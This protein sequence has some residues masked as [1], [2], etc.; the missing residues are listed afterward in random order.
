MIFLNFDTVIILQYP[1]PFLI[2][3]SKKIQCYSSKLIG[4]IFKMESWDLLYYAY[5]YI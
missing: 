3:E 2:C 1:N 5:I 4:T